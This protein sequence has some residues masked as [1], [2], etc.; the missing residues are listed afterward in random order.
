MWGWVVSSTWKRV[1]GSYMQLACTKFLQMTLIM[2][3]KTQPPQEVEGFFQPYHGELSGTDKEM[4]ED[5]CL[6]RRESLGRM[7]GRRDIYQ[8]F[9]LAEAKWIEIKRSLTCLPPPMS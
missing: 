3:L 6:G 5:V 8:F 1:L 4:V 9:S 2:L 7:V